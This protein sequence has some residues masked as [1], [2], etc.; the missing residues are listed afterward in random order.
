MK[1]FFILKLK[2]NSVLLS[3]YVWL[4]Y[5]FSG[6]FLRSAI[7]GLDEFKQ[8]TGLKFYILTW[9]AVFCYALKV[10]I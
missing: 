4:F 5:V 7:T 6:Q 3:I 8:K 2:N 1:V 9:G 10:I